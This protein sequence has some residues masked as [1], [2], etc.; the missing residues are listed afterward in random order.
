MLMKYMKE[1]LWVLILTALCA[2]V[3]AG[4]FCL[5]RLPVEAVGYGALLCGKLAH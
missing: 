2:A 4:V 5:Y 1:R 3:F